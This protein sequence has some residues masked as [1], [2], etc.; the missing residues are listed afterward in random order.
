MELAGKSVEEK[1]HDLRKEL[2]KKK[3]CGII[4]CIECSTF[5]WLILL[6]LTRL[7]VAM[8]DEIAWLFNLRGNEYDF[9]F[10]TATA[11]SR[12]LTWS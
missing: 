9:S 10:I 6:I 2:E 12:Q 1:I 4:I 3:K 11:A 5:L 8:L 7:G